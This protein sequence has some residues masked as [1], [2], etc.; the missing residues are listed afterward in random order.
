MGSMAF[1]DPQKNLERFGLQ[2]GH[3]VADLG[4]GSGFYTLVAAKMVGSGTVYAVDVQ[5]ELLTRLRGLTA[6]EKLAN[7]HFVHADAEQKGGTKIK[8]H[9][10]DVVLMCNVLFQIEQKD[11]FLEEA[12]RILKPTGRIL[13]V[14]WTD[15]FGGLGPQSQHVIGMV[16][17]RE[18]FKKHGFTEISTIDA[19]DHHYGISF[20]S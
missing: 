4:A 11:D 17:A 15:S 10:V 14:D 8:D 2:E 19:G 9:T 6:K 13:L 7:V 3:V 12:K 1:S 5:A 16:S 18:L 20:R